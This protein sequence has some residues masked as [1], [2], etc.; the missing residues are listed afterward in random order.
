MSIL[1]CGYHFACL[2]SWTNVSTWDVLLSEHDRDVIVSSLFGQV[3]HRAGSILVILA[4]D[5]SL[6]RAFNRQTQTTLPSPLNI[7]SELSSFICYGS[8]KTLEEQRKEQ[9]EITGSEYLETYY[10][11]LKLCTLALYDGFY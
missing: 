2:H 7:H 8:L 1:C 11:S 9:D 6:C 5:L 10:T 3:F 4:A